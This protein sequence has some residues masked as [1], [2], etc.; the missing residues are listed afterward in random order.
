MKAWL[1]MEMQP[2]P[3]PNYWV[4]GIQEWMSDDNLACQQVQS[5]CESDFYSIEGMVAGSYIHPL[6]NISP[7]P[8]RIEMRSWENQCHAKV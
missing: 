7:I 5:N 2:H 8:K 4:Q 1:Q 6:N 3:R